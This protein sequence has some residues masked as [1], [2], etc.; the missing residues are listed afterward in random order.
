VQHSRGAV[1]AFAILLCVA[2]VSPRCK[3]EEPVRLP[4][5]LAEVLSAAQK[6]LAGGRPA[7]VIRR[8]SAFQGQDH[9]LRHLLLGH[10]YVRQ[11]DLPKAAR[12]YQD[13]LAIDGSM[14]EAGLGLAQVRAR[15]GQ[16]GKA[17]ELL[18]RFTSL[19]TCEADLVLLYAQAARHLEDRR[20]SGLLV[21]KGI[22]RFPHDVRFRRLDLALCIDT[23]DHPGT[24]RAAMHLLKA[25]PTDAALWQHV[26]LAAS[27]AKEDVGR[28]AALE[29]SLLCDPS[30][31]ARHRRFLAAELAAG[32]WPTVVGHGRTLLEG[33][34]GKAA[35]ADAGTMEL[36]LA[37]ADMG[38]QN[39]I[40]AAW[41]DRVGQKAH[42][43]AMRLVAARLALRQG[44][45]KAAREALAPL[46]EAGETDP[47]VF[48]WAGHLAETAQDWP[49]AE[50]LYRHA[51][52]LKGRASQL[53]T[54]YLARLY[55]H[56]ERRTEAARLLRGH[57]D[58]YPED[59][60][61]RALLALA[62][63]VPQ[64]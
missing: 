16:W 11:S 64:E 21:R 14:K 6:D 55:L 39:D 20:L 27:G 5:D 41:L 38:R 1:V 33:P 7:E 34:L 15:Q 18:G 61:A 52:T 12:A 40:L 3:A 24:T 37:A 17:A 25:D 19:D 30:D 62:D 54:L 47:A 23:A 26:A 50:T 58:T 28:I 35:L 43:R 56:R 63:A 10:A 46:I 32:N 53:A 45:T 44:K 2:L 13:A 22:L 57:L 4:R 36:L 29:A 59:A 60:P 49:E 8:L 31:L 51:R 9:A 42:T 48:L